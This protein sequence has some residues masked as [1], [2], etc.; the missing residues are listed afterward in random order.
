MAVEAMLEWPSRICTMRILTP[1]SISLV[2]Y[3]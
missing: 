2:A 3:E 1:F